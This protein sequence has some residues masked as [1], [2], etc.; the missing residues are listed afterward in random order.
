MRCAPYT[1]ASRLCS[2]HA[3]V[4]LEMGG[5]GVAT[6]PAPTD[7]SCKAYWCGVGTLPATAR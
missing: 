4:V 1:V 6:A 7:L 5:A 2:G 3:F